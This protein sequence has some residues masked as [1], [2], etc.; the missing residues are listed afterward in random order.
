MGDL[1]PVRTAWAMQASL[2][3]GSM[4]GMAAFDERDVGVGLPAEL[5]RGTRKQ[6]C[7]GGDLRVHLHADHHFPIARGAFDQRALGRHLLVLH[8]W[9]PLPNQWS[10]L[11][12]G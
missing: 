5:R 12:P 9:H 11:T 2:M 8:A 3:R 1:S 10:R 7:L 6:L 4:P